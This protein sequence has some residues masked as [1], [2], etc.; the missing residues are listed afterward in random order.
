MRKASIHFVAEILLLVYIYIFFSTEILSFFHLLKR[1]VVV[2]LD[3][4]FILLLFCIY[5]RRL[6]SFI[7]KIFGFLKDRIYI[8]ILILLVLTF[9]QG[10]M[11]APSTTDS[12]V[13]HLPRIMYWQQE[14]TLFQDMVRNSHDFM[15]PFG[16]YILFHLYSLVGGDRLLF[17]SQWVAYLTSIYLSGV[18]ALQFKA[19]KGTAE[20]TALLVALLPMGVMQAVSTQVDMVT[21]VLVLITLHIALVLSRSVSFKNS[22]FLGFAV[23]LGVM[24][25]VS[26]AFYLIVPLGILL[27]RMVKTKFVELWKLVLAGAIA[28]IIQTQYL[29]QNLR[30]FGSLPGKHILSSGEEII[31]TNEKFSVGIT[32]SNFIRNIMSQ[33]PIPIFTGYFQTALE[34]FH[35]LI[36]TPLNLPA[37]TYDYTIFKV[38]SVLYPQEDI[39]ANPLH[40]ILIV[41][42]GFIVLRR[43]F[44]KK[45]PILTVAYICLFISLVLFSAILKWQPFHSR[46]LIPFFAVG[47][48]LAVTV[49]DEFKRGRIFLY[50]VLVLSI[51]LVLLLILFNVSRPYISYTPFYQ[52]VKQFSSP[53]TPMPVSFFVKNRN[54]QYF[55]SRPYWYLPYIQIIDVLAK[56]GETGTVSFDLMDDF[57]YPLWVFIKDKNINI[58][59]IP[60]SKADDSTA[61]ITTTEFV[62]Q[63]EGY[64]NFCVKTVI[65]YGYA[66]LSIK[67]KL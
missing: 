14:A 60:L 49:L 35:N 25:K 6:V 8:F 28:I 54:E 32:I 18:L 65:D 52:T 16:E 24:T 29:L 13:Y 45:F 3:L 37:S 7:S 1:G 2:S 51:P 59:V 39:V 9:V 44:Y 12:M 57:E 63:K 58:R 38:N 17:L 47:S 34:E 30:L 50:I 48:I 64:S 23:G 61:I 22:L 67:E 66:C 36:N 40:L 11:S 33:I 31:Y 19:S 15:A 62:I 53:L 21:A 10:L 56:S 26:F 41:L 27:I 46:L 5:R 43:A 20:K 42:I 4:A 55:N